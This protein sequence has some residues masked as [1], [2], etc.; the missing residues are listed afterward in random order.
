ME[1]PLSPLEFARRTRRLHGAREAVVDG[2]LRLTYE[3]FFDRCDRWSAALQGLGVRPGRPGRHHRAQHARPARGVLRRAAARR[4]AGADELP[5]HRRRLRL[6]GQP[7]RLHRAVRAQRLPGRDRRGP[8]PAA[9]RAA[10]RRVRGRRRAV[11]LA[12]LRGAD[13]GDQ[14]RL[15]P[16]RDR[17]AGPADDQLH[18]RHHVPAQGRDDH[19]PQR[20]HEH[21]RHPAP[22]ADGR[23]RPLPVD[24]ADVPRQRV[25]VH[26]DGHRGRRRPTSACARSSPPL[27]SR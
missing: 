5:A 10:L 22:P 24:A 18:Q 25:D 19:P 4:G 9:R 2:D 26:L 13:R 6:H 12:R 11:R 15:R 14:P 1:T 7:L 3:E 8:R 21:R 20:L 27:S 17:R 16:A 23:G